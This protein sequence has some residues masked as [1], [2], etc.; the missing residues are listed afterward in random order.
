MARSGPHPITLRQLQYA[1][2]VAEHRGFRKAA[3]ACAVAQPSLSAQIAQLES[4]LGV[5]L[6]ERLPRGLVITQAGSALLERARCTV[7]EADD[8]VDAAE[9]ARDP[10]AGTVRIG[11]LPT[12]APYLLPEMA[13]VVR[14]RCPGLHILWFEE[15]TGTLLERLGEGGLDAGIMAQ[16]SDLGDL[17]HELIG[18]DDFVLATPRGHRLARKHGPAQLGDLDGETILL[19]DDGHCFR[20][21]ALAVCGR[22]GATEASVRATSLATLAQMVAGGEGITLL[23]SL[24]VKSENRA[25]GLAIRAFGPRGPAR[26]LVLTWRRTSPVDKAMRVLADAMRDVM[27]KLH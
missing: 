24:A 27:R 14:N 3:D 16:E 25:G 4:A 20:D 13:R 15:K 8:L 12:I 21:Q 18:R 10:L 6:F 7:R 2:A 23:P 5:V 9:R 19:L 22:A 17:T 26:T 11:V 1:L